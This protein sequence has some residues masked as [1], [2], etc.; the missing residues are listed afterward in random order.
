MEYLT[1]DLRAYDCIY[2]QKC[3]V[4]FRTGKDVPKEFKQNSGGTEAEKGRP[5]ND[6][7]NEAFLQT[8]MY[9]EI[10]EQERYEIKDLVHIMANY[11]NETDK[12]SP[13]PCHKPFNNHYMK[14]EL[15][16]KCGESVHIYMPTNRIRP[17]MSHC[18]IAD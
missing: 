3:S 4:N 11:L 9:I 16:E 14:Q 5:M 8:C 13:G 17:Y 6:V 7:Q 1:N 2:H 18:E 15:I 10:N 12:N